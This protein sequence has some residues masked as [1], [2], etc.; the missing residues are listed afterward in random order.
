MQDSAGAK[1]FGSAPSLASA[2]SGFCAARYS[3]RDA[4]VEGFKMVWDAH[5][6]GEF[7]HTAVAVLT[8]DASG[9]LQ[10]ERHKCCVECVDLGCQQVVANIG[11]DLTADQLEASG[12]VDRVLLRARQRTERRIAPAEIRAVQLR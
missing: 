12:G 4:A 8:K 1:L 2:S 3:S 10:V 5:K 11:D 6:G 9:K 7:D